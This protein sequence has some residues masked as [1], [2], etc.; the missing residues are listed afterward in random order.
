MPRPVPLGASP[1]ANE[2]FETL[3]KV[4]KT[5]CISENV[6]SVRF[7]YGSSGQRT[8]L[9]DSSGVTKVSRSGVKT[10]DVSS[11]QNE[12]SRVDVVQ[13]HLLQNSAD[14]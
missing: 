6:S 13:G 11:S 1:L 9:V 4:A 8:D 2:T 14:A 10:V 7:L 5:I 3:S 12:G